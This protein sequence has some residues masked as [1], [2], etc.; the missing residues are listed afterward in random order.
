MR[1][2]LTAAIAVTLLIGAAYT[3][4]V[5]RSVAIKPASAT[6]TNVAGTVTVKD[7][8]GRDV[9]FDVT[10]FGLR[11][12][13]GGTGTQF[14]N[15]EV[16]HPIDR[17]SPLLAA[18]TSGRVHEVT[19]TT[20]KP[21]TQDVAGIYTL[22]DAQVVVLDQSPGASTKELVAFRFGRIEYHYGPNAYCQN[23]D[24]SLGC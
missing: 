20:F 23:T 19:I 14:S 1:Y 4:S 13:T 16:T 22:S 21:G 18:D 9:T 10:D 2:R 15:F 3:A 6:A 12:S 8:F 11:I 24:G 5:P 7:L 17:Y